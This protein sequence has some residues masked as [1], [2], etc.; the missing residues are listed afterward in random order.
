MARPSKAVSKIR[1]KIEKKQLT[2]QLKKSRRKAKRKQRRKK[3]RSKVAPARIEGKATKHEL[4]KLKQTLGDTIPADSVG[5]TL[6]GSA[7]MTLGGAKAV[8]SAVE[9]NLDRVEPAEYGVDFDGD[10]TVDGFGG[11]EENGGVD[12]T[13][14]GSGTDDG[15]VSGLSP[16]PE[17]PRAGSSGTD[18]GPVSGLGSRS[19]SS[20][21]DDEIRFI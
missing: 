3:I 9:N 16:E 20:D 13:F 10:G 7:K 21:E 14:G 4:G 18:D 8:G 12:L 19:R 1:E 6:K 5:S 11:P 17:S 15:P 2:K